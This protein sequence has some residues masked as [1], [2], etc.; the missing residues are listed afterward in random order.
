MAARDYYDALGVSRDAS[1]EEVQQAFRKLARQYH[2]DVNK[3]PAAEE[4][5]KEIN[6]AYSVLSDPATRKRYDRFGPDFRQVPEGY[7]DYVG[8]GGGG[9]RP[10]SG[11]RGGAPFGGGSVWVDVGGT[12]EGGFREAG[13]IDFDDLFGG[14]FGSRGGFGSVA[15]AD[16]EAEV[17]LTVEEAYRGGRRRVTLSTPDGEPTTFE[18]TIPAGV[19]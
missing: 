10:R 8:A 17:E 18:V 5:F 3:D 16:Q 9:A 14:L 1:S 11:A 19:T 6:E 2:P 7:E 15:G 13:G 12:G 4:R